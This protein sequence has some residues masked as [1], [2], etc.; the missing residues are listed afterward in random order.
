VSHNGRRNFNTVIL[1]YGAVLCHEPLPQEIE[2]MSRVFGVTPEHFPALYSASRQAYDRGDLSTAEYWRS[3]AHDSGVEL[4]P[5]LMEDLAQ[6]DKEMWSRANVEMTDWLAALRSAGYQT[7]LLSN[8]QHDMIAHIRAKFPWLANFHHQIF[9]SE[10]R[11]LKP[12]PAIYLCCLEQLRARPREAIFVDDREENVA[13]AR[14]LGMAAFRFR[15][16]SELRRDLELA[17]FRDLP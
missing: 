12:E 7:A 13:A 17:D 9:S 10:V 14:S 11:A 5:E 3:V 2:R 15:S 4:T 6:W 16:V 1:D 8:M